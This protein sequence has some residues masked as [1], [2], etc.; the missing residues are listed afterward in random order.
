[1]EELSSNLKIIEPDSASF[2][3]FDISLEFEFA[4]AG[5]KARRKVSEKIGMKI[6][7]S[8]SRVMFSYSCEVKILLNK[9]I[10]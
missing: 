6:D 10:T 2:I 3:G 4:I 7:F 8:A 5:F 1:M 9:S